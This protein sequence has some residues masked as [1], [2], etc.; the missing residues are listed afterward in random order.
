MRKRT[1]S[2]E[3][4]LQILYQIDITG[5]DADTA[6]ENYWSGHKE[7]EGARDFCNAIT[8]G[9]V[10]NKELI[11]TLITRYAENWEIKRMAV[12][13][14]NILR[15][16]AYELLFLEDVPPKVSI[17]EAIELA[18]KFG[19]SES[20][21]FVNGIIDKINKSEEA[22]RRKSASNTSTASGE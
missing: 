11:D 22:C 4:A 20:G 1:K 13:D 10:S 17:N 19:D 6:L 2:R 12:V 9:T 5:V 21:R 18:K 16:A 3:C 7:D 15:L 14:R 8:K